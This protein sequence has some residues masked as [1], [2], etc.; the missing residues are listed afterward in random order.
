MVH[1]EVLPRV[2][3]TIFNMLQEK[4]IMQSQSKCFHA[5]SHRRSIQGVREIRVISMSATHQYKTTEEEQ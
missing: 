3:I 5:I 4:Q 1:S 2:R